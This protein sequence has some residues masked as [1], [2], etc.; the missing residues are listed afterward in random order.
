MSSWLVERGTALLDR[1]ASRRG[2]LTRAALVGAAVMVAPL[3]YV[4]RPGSAYAAICSCNGSSCNCTDLCCD[5]Y[6]EFCCT[7]TGENRC[8]P[9]T[10]AAGW[11]KADGSGFCDVDGVSMPRYYLD[12][13]AD[14]NGCGCGS[15]GLCSRTCA[16]CNCGCAQGNCANRKACCTS[17]RYG[18]CNQDVRCVGPIVCR[19]VTCVA[20]WEI[21][22]SCTTASA[23]D[24]ATRFHNRPCLQ[25]AGSSLALAG[26]VRGTR[27]LLSGALGDSAA[28]VTLDYGEEDDVFVMGDWNGDGTK[29]PGLVRGTRYGPFGGQLTWLLKNDFE[30]GPPDI[31]LEFG[32]A[33][34]VPVVG[35]WNGDGISG[36]G[37]F[38][39]GH[40]Q[41]RN[42]L[43]PGPPDSEFEFG[44]AGDVPLAGDWNGTGGQ[45]IGV[46]RGAQFRLRIANTA[47]PVDISVWYGSPDDTPV[48]GDWDGDGIDTIGVVRDNQWLLR[49]TNSAG[50]SHINFQFGNEG[51]IP[52]VWGR[53]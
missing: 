43:L 20:P 8:P 22:P 16:D 39:D 46:R 48:V 1:R 44:E 30:P 11:W 31:V 36:L 32:D 50:N 23:T 10:L 6:T 26:V 14:C 13:N 2:F 24:N 3:R 17:F 18:Q 29:T 37:A 27:W 33:G 53:A 38:K 51:D 25:G 19:I 45:K 5:G 40:W 21:E 7:L 52:V 28:A 12:C 42:Q 4:L 49:N 9:G 34:S 41:L 35:D 47:G 15:N